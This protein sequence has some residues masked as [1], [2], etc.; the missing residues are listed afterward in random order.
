MIKYLENNLQYILKTFLRAK[1]AT[2][3][4]LLKGLYKKTFK[5]LIP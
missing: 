5:N 3:I 2:P 4:V 1:I